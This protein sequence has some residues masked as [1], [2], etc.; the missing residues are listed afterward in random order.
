MI[1]CFS[2]GCVLPAFHPLPVYESVYVIGKERC[3]ASYDRDIS[4]LAYG[5][6]YPQHNQHEVV[7]RVGQCEVWT[8]A[9]SG[10]DH[11]P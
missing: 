8:A 1:F 5:G 9:E 10:I 6:K 2:G 3:K 11:P 4:R 7:C